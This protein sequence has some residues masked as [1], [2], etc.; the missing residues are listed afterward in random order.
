MDLDRLQ[1]HLSEL[2]EDTPRLKVGAETPLTPDIAF[3][4]D[5]K[6]FELVEGEGA[7]W[8]RLT[9]SDS[10]SAPTPADGGA[11]Q[12]HG[13]EV[14]VRTVW[15]G[16]RQ[17]GKGKGKEKAQQV[18]AGAE[19]EHSAECDHEHADQ[20]GGQGH[21]RDI[22]EEGGVIKRDQLEGELEKLSFEIYR[23]QHPVAKSSR[24]DTRQSKV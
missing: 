17:P 9:G 4:L 18:H 6:L 15:R 13:D 19:H 24:S 1:D 2:N 5:T 20:D 3:G 8:S 23:G 16:G 14:E 11:G 7:D 21:G 22:M 12:W 10:G